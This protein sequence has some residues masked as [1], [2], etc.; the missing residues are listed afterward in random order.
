MA[1]AGRPPEVCPA[2]P[3]DVRHA[4][5]VLVLATLLVTS[6]CVSLPTDGSGGGSAG[7]AAPGEVRVTVTGV[8][9]GDT[10]RVRFRNGSTDTVRLLSV[11]TPETRGDNAPDEFEGVPETAAGRECLR[12][13][14][15]EA[16]RV[17]TRRL[18]S[19]SVT[20]QY[21]PRA[22]R[23]GYYG[24]L[25]AY[26]VHDGENV[27]Y[28]LVADGHARVYDSTFTESDRFYAAESDAQSSRAGLW[29]CRDP[30]AATFDTA[31]PTATPAGDGIV[32]AE[33][34]ADAAGRDGE[35]LNDEYVVLANRGDDAVDLSGWTVTD[36]ADHT[37]RFPD[38]ATLDPGAR[39]TLHTGSDTDSDTDRYWDRGSPVW[40]NDG[41][42][43]TVRDTS[44]TVVAQRTYG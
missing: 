31:T 28:R 14:G 27:N 16:T 26:V 32:V 44:G 21:D 5:A 2:Q 40:N 41:D 6:G 17:M 24:R 4:T 29:T 10:I 34:H 3:P 7:T 25:L 13:A 35:N 23:R 33:I 20:L 30:D 11:D 18:L 42:T 19:E 39:V 15:H 43:V 22:D 12:A 8:I 37:Y 1:R 9:D 38:G 36:A